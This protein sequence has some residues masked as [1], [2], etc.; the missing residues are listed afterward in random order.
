[1][2]LEIDTSE[3]M[4]ELYPQEQQ[5]LRIE[6]GN[7]TDQALYSLVASIGDLAEKMLQTEERQNQIIQALS[8]LATEMKSDRDAI[9]A[10]L[11]TEPVI[12]V[13]VPEP[14]VNITVPETVVHVPEAQITVQPPEVNI[15]MEAPTTERKIVVQ[16]DPLTGLISSADV[17]ES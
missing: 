13:T 6:V 15:T 11:Q 16:R 4:D 8:D 3:L 12:N 1:M 10:S 14:V 7:P 5:A 17:V 2:S 9:V